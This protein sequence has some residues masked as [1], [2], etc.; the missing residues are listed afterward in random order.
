M[1]SN[2]FRPVVTNCRCLVKINWRMNDWHCNCIS[3]Q[4]SD[5]DMIVVK[6]PFTYIYFY[7]YTVAYVMSNSVYWRSTWLLSYV[8]FL[9][10]GLLLTW[11][12]VLR[13][14][15]YTWLWFCNLSDCCMA[16]VTAAIRD[17]PVALGNPVLW[18]LPGTYGLWITP[19]I[20][21]KVRGKYKY[22]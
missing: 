6:L 16:P 20:M 21:T 11:I 9:S 7:F 14:D 4:K 19:T 15:K 8:H 12:S 3:L 22:I 13:G 1:Y 2:N 18:S 17:N 10:M 5:L